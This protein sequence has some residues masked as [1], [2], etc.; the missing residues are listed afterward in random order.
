M[1]KA[2]IFDL[3]GVLVDSEPAYQQRFKRFFDMK[4]SPLSDEELAYI[5]GSNSR[6]TY[7]CVVTKHFPGL[8]FDEYIA[9][10]R[11]YSQA[12]PI[13][14]KS[15]MFPEVEAALGQVQ[16]AGYR[17]AL[18]SSSNMKSIENILGSC[19]IGGYFENILSG[20]MFRESKPH[21]EI[22][23]KSAE[24]LG[25]RPDECAA[26]EDSEPGIRS[27]VDAGMTVIARRD[28]QFGMDQQAAHYMVDSIAEALPIIENM[29]DRKEVE[30]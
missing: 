15:I 24:L 22:Y 27:A 19:G 3:D 12:T 26:V 2:V 14:Y 28:T 4:Q 6:R 7:A 23:L 10:F 8:P 29:K 16:Q 21:P 13:D 1:I 18:A 30:F 5:V 25:L 20:D 9:E 17:L 11:A